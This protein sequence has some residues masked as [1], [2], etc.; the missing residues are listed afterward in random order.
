MTTSVSAIRSRSGEWCRAMSAIGPKQKSLVALH[1][2]A[3]G[4][5]ADMAFCGA[6]RVVWATSAD[7]KRRNS[8]RSGSGLGFKT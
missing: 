5:E 8:R 4:G 1:M 3:F 6:T 2:S 7:H